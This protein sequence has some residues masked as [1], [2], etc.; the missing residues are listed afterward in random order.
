MKLKDFFSGRGNI[1]DAFVFS[2]I[3]LTRAFKKLSNAK[4]K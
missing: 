2:A 3:S 1:R 4:L